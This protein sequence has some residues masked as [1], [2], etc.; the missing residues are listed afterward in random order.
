[1]WKG[2]GIIFVAI[3]LLFFNKNLLAQEEQIAL[4]DQYYANGEV[5]KAAGIYKI[6]SAN[7]DNLEKIYT[8]YF[9]LLINLPDLKEAARLNTKCVKT[10]SYK[11]PYQADAIFLCQLNQPVTNSKKPGIPCKS[12]L[13]ADLNEY[14]DFF[15]DQNDYGKRLIFRALFDQA[16]WWYEAAQKQA[17]SRYDFTPS[18]IELYQRSRNTD[19]LL[20]TAFQWLIPHPEQLEAV[21]LMLQESLADPSTFMQAE[22]K[23]YA[24]IQKNPDKV[25]FNH[26]VYW[27]YIQQMDIN[28]AF[29]QAK[30]IDKNEGLY[31]ATCLELARFAISNNRLQEALPVLAYIYQ[32]YPQSLPAY[33]A[34][35]QELM[36]RER[37]LVKTYPVDPQ[38]LRDLDFQYAQL[39]LAGKGNAQYQTADLY[40]RR[41]LLKARYFNDLDSATYLINEAIRLSTTLSERNTYKLDL[42][43]FSV[44][45]KDY[46]EAI[47][48]Y[49]QV[50][51][52]MKEDVVGHEAKLRKARVFYYKGEFA[53]AKEQLD[54]LKEATSREIAN[55]ALQ[56]SVLIQD[57]TGLDSTEEAM[58][59]YAH[60]DLLLFQGLYPQAF[61]ESS[62]LLKQ[63]PKHSITD[64]LY[65]QRAILY[66]RTARYSEAIAE[67]DKILASYA[68]DILADDALF[69]MGDIYQFDLLQNDNALKA[70]ERLIN[71]HSSSTYVVEI[72]RRYR[73][74][75]GD[76]L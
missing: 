68:D 15:A 63:Y 56:L 12:E 30:A 50:E 60:V 72:R 36:V 29:I 51:K 7:A 66:R 20:E 24:F 32:S 76:K 25:V 35:K 21:Q 17:G 64:E 39:I 59:A 47:L 28:Q 57:N 11:I 67:L 2:K 48:I 45:N 1:M 42:G 46:W 71:E 38:V 40:R 10:L 44:L 13:E 19:K 55:D 33:E 16:S 75:R 37:M 74:L 5:D 61:E 14:K 4:A 70:Y 3:V 73:I 52:D 34:R 65:W 9:A 26:L 31:G 18:L 69:M 62:A 53:L 49:G 22:E 58:K 43:D 6:L 54:I 27:M 41:A 8:N 23:A